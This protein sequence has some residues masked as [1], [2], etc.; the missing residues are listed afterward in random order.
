[1]WDCVEKLQSCIKLINIRL[2]GKKICH[3][4]DLQIKA[5]ILLVN[6]V[7]EGGTAVCNQ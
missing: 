5:G 3:L 6:L 2:A 4:T 1:M 7:S